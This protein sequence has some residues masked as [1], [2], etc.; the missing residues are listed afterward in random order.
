MEM[1]ANGRPMMSS[2]AR[3]IPG[4]ESPARL[5]NNVSRIGSGNRLDELKRRKR[6]FPLLPNSESGTLA[7]VFD[8]FETMMVSGRTGGTGGHAAD[9]APGRPAASASELAITRQERV[10]GIC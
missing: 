5:P 4:P 6:S 3:K 2:A 7:D 10:R 9:A 1:N 8:G